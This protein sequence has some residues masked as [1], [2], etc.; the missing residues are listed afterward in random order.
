MEPPMPLWRIGNLQGPSQGMWDM[1]A[2]APGIE[3]G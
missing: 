3:H 2:V 1:H